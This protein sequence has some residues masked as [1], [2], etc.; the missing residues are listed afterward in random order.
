MATGKKFVTLPNGN[1]AVTVA[2]DDVAAVAADDNCVRIKLAG[3]GEVHTTATHLETCN[4]L[5]IEPGA[6]PKPAKPAK[7]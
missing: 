2:P 3:G 6:L 1:H 7:K 5:G 4:A